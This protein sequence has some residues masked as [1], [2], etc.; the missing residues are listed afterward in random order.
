[1]LFTVVSTVQAKIIYYDSFDGPSGEDLNGMAPIVTTNGAVWNAGSDIN[2]DGIIAQSV[3]QYS[4]DSAYLPFTPE[5]GHIYELSVTMDCTT[6]EW[7]GVGFTQS[8]SPADRFLEQ[9]VYWWAL[10]CGPDS[11]NYDQTFIGLRTSGAQDTSTRGEDDILILLDTTGQTWML[12]WYFDGVLVRTEEVWNPGVIKYVS[13]STSQSGG[14]IS[15]FKL[16]IPKSQASQP[17]PEDG[18]ADVPPEVVLTWTP[19]EF[20]NKHDVYLGTDFN[21]VN[22]ATPTNDPNYVYMG[23]FDSNAYPEF[24]TVRLDIGRRYFWRVD[25]VNAPPNEAIY[26]GLVWSFDMEPVTYPISEESIAVTASSYIEDGSP[27]NT[28]NGSGLVDGLH[29]VDTTAMWLS[30]SGEP[31]SV[32]IEYE[33]DKAYKLDRMWVW[34]YNGPIILWKFGIRD[35]TV[36]YS[37]DGYYWTRIDS[38]SEFA[39]ASSAAGYLCNNTVDFNDVAVKNVRIFANSNWSDG[40]FDQYGLSEVRFMYK[41]VH[42]REPGPAEGE[43]D[44][45]VDVTLDWRPG[46]EADR[47][48]IYLSADKQA[49]TEGTIPFSNV[50]GQAGYGPLS[51]DL[52]STYYWRVDEVNNNEAI[53]IWRGE[54][55]SFSTNEYHVVDD[56]ESYNDLNPEEEG[57]NR[58]FLT[59]TD[60]YDNPTFNGST[61]G[62]TDPDF[63]NDEHFVEANIVHGGNQSGPFLYNNTTASYSEVSLPTSATTLGSNWTQ[64]EG[65]FNVL[66]LWFYGDPNNPATESLYIKLNDSK[67]TY[68]GN[69]ADLSAGQWIQWDINLS[70]FVGLNLASVTGLTVGA[71]RAGAI[72]SEGILFLDDIR[73]RYVVQ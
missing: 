68:N 64:G 27:E 41:P 48:Y 36:E 72:G 19:G 38:V 55:W 49:V 62:Y 73:L 30:D 46:R 13:F 42:A 21:D 57:S 10:T 26:K 9:G 37:N 50:P 16:E 53:P 69:A 3:S 24:G 29:T 66:T 58:V 60:G 8:K 34:N 43:T 33:F 45:A 70:D 22:D 28:I 65:D 12:Q 31:G 11:E 7:M 18:Q 25:E 17:S 14:M 4:G 23:R 32:G 59:W 20:A 44:V 15:R 52:E 71:E 6:G 5:S 67:V 1:M 40:L 63:A 47:H 56:F 39:P 2:A 54:I 35:V 61:M 51:L